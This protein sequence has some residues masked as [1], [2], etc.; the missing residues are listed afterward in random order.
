M[1]LYHV[2]PTASL[3]VML[4]DGANMVRQVVLPPPEGAITLA[5]AEL[6][7]TSVVA[8]RSEDARAKGFFESPIDVMDSY[9][10]LG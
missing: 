1:H 9:E 3:G 5:P 4:K 10:A 7:A 8:S 2:R 6:S